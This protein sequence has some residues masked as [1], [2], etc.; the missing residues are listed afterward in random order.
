MLSKDEKRNLLLSEFKRIDIDSN[1]LLSK[2]EF[3][4]ALDD[5]I[6]SRITRTE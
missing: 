5:K 4:R 6:V 1:D 3:F 2:E